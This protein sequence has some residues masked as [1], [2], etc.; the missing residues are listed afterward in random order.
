MKGEAFRDSF[1]ARY[2]PAFEPE[3]D[4]PTGTMNVRLRGK[5]IITALAWYEA[6]L[7][8]TSFGW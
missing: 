7:V 4:I 1:I 6:Y 2:E 8:Q 3:A 5:A